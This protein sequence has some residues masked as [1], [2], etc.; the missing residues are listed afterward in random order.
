MQLYTI[1]HSAHPI[2]KFIGLLQAQAIELVVDVRS[3]PA[4]RFH[5]HFTKRRLE[6]SL[7]AV[8]IGYAYLGQALG[9]RP[10][11]P[12]C[13]PDGQAAQK[14][15]SRFARPDFERVMA[16]DWF[17]EGSARLL[18]LAREQRTVMLC[19]EENPAF[20][21]R[22]LLIYEFLH[23]H[24]PEVQVVHLRGDG[25]RHSPE[26][27]TLL[28]LCTGN[29]YRSRFAESLF[30]H[31]AVEKGLFWKAES[32]GIATELGYD[33]RGPISAMTVEGLAGCG[34]VSEGEARFPWQLEAA[35]LQEAELVIALEEAEHRPLLQRRFPGWE[36]QVQYWQ[37]HDLHIT[38]AGEAVA[39]MERQVRKLVAQLSDGRAGGNK[40]A[41]HG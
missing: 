8:N 3:V 15:S 37:I 39:L 17:Q 38:P 14:N 26:K 35:D 16:R 41:E 2:G 6:D 33:N 28:F 27:R 18:E 19:S 31:L 7:Q 21:H 20:C 34:V 9:G 11:D 30:N 36:E 24:H 22:H 4:S 29:Y 10:A 5:P 40:E 13:Y 25:T 12:S 23:R 1:G 32:R